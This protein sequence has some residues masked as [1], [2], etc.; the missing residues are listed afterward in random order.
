[1]INLIRYFDNSAAWVNTAQPTSLPLFSYIRSLTKYCIS[2]EIVGYG[3][4]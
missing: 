3:F 2:Y 1:M 4:N